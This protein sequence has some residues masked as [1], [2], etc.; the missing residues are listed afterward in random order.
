ML[1]LILSNLVKS[2]PLSLL[3]PPT[4]EISASTIDLKFQPPVVAAAT[5]VSFDLSSEPSFDL[6]DFPLL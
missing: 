4:V 2:L 6:R 1:T 3:R 5:R